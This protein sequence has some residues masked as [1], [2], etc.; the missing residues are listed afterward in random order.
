MTSTL[1]RNAAPSDDSDDEGPDDQEGEPDGA[2]SGSWQAAAGPPVSDDASGCTGIVSSTIYPS[3]R[4]LSPEAKAHIK[5][6]KI[7]K[8]ADRITHV[9][10]RVAEI[11]TGMLNPN[12]QTSQKLQL[13]AD[14]SPAFSKF[15]AILLTQLEPMLLLVHR[16][17][18]K[19]VERDLVRTRSNAHGQGSNLKENPAPPSSKVSFLQLAEKNIIF[20]DNRKRPL[21]TLEQM[22]GKHGHTASEEVLAPMILENMIQAFH[23]V[24]P[25]ARAIPTP[26]DGIYANTPMDQVMES[27]TEADIMRF[28]AYVQRFPKAYLGK[29]FR[30]TEAFAGW[31][32]SGTPED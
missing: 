21:Y 7:D 18:E 11:K 10:K 5:E 23:E 32:V 13:M 6:E 12:M 22:R 25:K 3:S 15:L 27:I 26:T 29:N 20:C 14:R 19:L 31:V 2:D 8:L 17:N 4:R 28:L 30:I 16:I 1:T 24:A 9:L